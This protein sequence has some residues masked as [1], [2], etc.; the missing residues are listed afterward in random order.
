MST[1]KSQMSNSELPQI[2]TS[3]NL[4]LGDI[5]KL[6]APTNPGLHDQIY[7]IKFINNSKLV[8]INSNGS[9]TLTLSQLGKIQ[10]ESIAN[11]I[12]LSRVSSPSFVVQNNLAIKKY[13]SIYFGEPFPYVVN[14]FISNIEN[15]MIEVTLL[16][17][18]TIIYIDFAY[19]GIPE[20]LNIDKIVVRDKL[21]ETQLAIQNDELQDSQTSLDD[22]TLVQDPNSMLDYDLKSYDSKDEIE[23]L[24]IDTIELGQELDDLEHEVNVSEEEQRYSLDK[25]TNDYLDKLINAY[26]PEQRNDA[27]I[28]Q[29]HNE[30]NYYIQLRSIYSNFDA[31]NYP[32]LP[33]ERG[34]HYKYL[35][36]Q[37]FN[38][39]KKMSFLFPVLE[40]ARN[41]LISESPDNEDELTSENAFNYQSMGEFIETL[42][43]TSLKWSNNSSKEKINNYKEHI[44][45]LT[46]LFDSY[47][48]NSAENINV[49]SQIMMI[50]DSIGDFYNYSI[51]KGSLS[52]SR[53]MIDVYNP[54]LM[55]LE[56]HYVNNKK[57]TRPTKLTANDYV[58]IVGFISLPLPLFKFS[59]INT[60]YTN[61]GDKAN[62]NINFI[63]ISDLLNT[64]TMYNTHILE[65]SDKANY[66]NSHNNIHNN[67]FLK[68]INHFTIDK[69]VDLPYLEKMNYLLE[70]FIP[71][72][73][74][75]IGE[76]ISAYV[77]DSLNYRKY[78]LISFIYDLQALNV[79]LYNL[80]YNDY[81][82]IKSVVQ[83]N[84]EVYKKIYKSNEAN[85][86]KFLYNI[87]A[88]NSDAIRGKDE[89]IIFSFDLLAKD[90]K[91]DLFNLYNIK[92]ELFNSYEELY[93]FIY[94]L[95][96]GEFFLQSLNKNIMDLVVGNLLDN[97]I[98]AREKELVNPDPAIPDTL[99]GTTPLS[100]KD[101]LLKDLDEIQATC[102]RYVLSKSYKTLQS[103]ENDNNKLIFYDSIYDKTLYSMANQFQNERKVMD[104][105]SFLQFLTE[106]LMTIMKLT[107]ANALREAKSIIEEK[108]EIIDG[109]YA[110]LK[111]K[112]SSKNYIYKREN[113][114]WV[115]DPTF[116][117]K[118]YIENNQIFCD[119]NKECIT[120]DDKCNSIDGTKKTNLN[121]EVDN[122][123]KTF[124]SKYNFSIE[125]IKSK[126]NSNYENAKKRIEKLASLNKAKREYGN[127]YLLSLEEIVE[128]KIISSPYESVRAS[129]LKLKDLSLK[130]ELLKRFC[131]NYTRNAI[132]DENANWL[133]CIKT[134]VKLVPQFLLR[135]A[136]VFLTKQNYVLELDTICAQQG[137]ISD[138]NNYWVDKH[139]GYIIK[140]IEFDND[141]GYDDKGFKVFSREQLE[142][143]YAINLQPLAKSLNPNIQVIINIIKAITLMMGINLSHN[144]EVIINNVLLVL[145]SN[146]PTKQKYEE[147]LLKTA[148]KEGKAKNNPSYDDMYN[149]SL[150]LLTLTFIVYA[151]QINI[152]SLTSKKTF[153]G[154]IKS[155]S[156]YPLD[157]EQDKTSI[158][159]IACIANKIK[160]SIVPWNSILKMSES[161][162]IKN[163]EQLIT[164]YVVTNKE[165][166]EHLN[167]KREF[168]LTQDTRDNS[169][170]DYLNINNWHT[171]NPP[172]N[173]IKIPS[174]ELE[175]LGVNFKTTLYDTFS[176]GQKNNIKDM[177]ESKAISCANHIIELIQNVVKSNTPLLK[178]SNDN[179]FLENAC[180]NSEKNTINYFTNAN[181]AIIDYNNLVGFYS[182]IVDGI[183]SLTYSPQIYI[184]LNTQQK[185]IT[186]YSAFSEEVVYKAFIYFCNFANQLPLD[187]ELKGL[188]M[189]KP[190][191]FDSTKSIKEI[192][193]ALKNEG[194]IYNF[195]SFVELI[196][197]VSKNNTINVPINFAIINNIEALRIIIEAYSN[198]SYYKLDDIFISKLELMLD[199]FSII[200]ENNGELRELKN[201]LGRTNMLLK[202]KI[203]QTVNKQTN[204]SKSEFASFSQTLD[205]VIDVENITFYQNYINNILH[206]FPSIIS[207]KNVNYDAIPKY[208]N[209]STLHYS[210]IYN[211]IKKYYVTLN[212][213]D[214]KHELEYAFKIVAKKLQLLTQLMKVFLYNKSLETSTKQINSIFDEKLITL[215]YNYIFYNIYNELLSINEDQDFML[216]I[217]NVETTDYNKDD[218]IKSIINYIMCFSNIMNNHYSLINNGY[219]RVKEKIVMAKEKE[220]TLIT[221]FLKNLSDEEREI[222]TILKNNKLEKWNVGMQKGLTQYV[223]ENY[224][225]EREA[226]DKQALKERK[227]QQ[228]NNVTS[229]NKEIYD[230]DLDEQMQNDAA[231]DAEEYS[232][233]NIP[234]DN[235][236]N[237]D[238]ADEDYANGFHED[239][240]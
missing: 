77:P 146:I 55:M 226:L 50:N 107:K 219:A 95:D 34:M 239:Y 53:F 189:D 194:K 207:N 153:P 24:I 40:N 147:L 28:K 56:S 52:K 91:D 97:F 202:Q 220:K 154:C 45:A 149:S 136:N 186:Q 26:L 30:I 150:L 156:G 71:T 114:V 94:S 89:N 110:V 109:D 133:Y 120:K 49:N 43:S 16:P 25:Q 14:G 83:D 79:D 68:T 235:D 200:D 155:F 59:L 183:A 184:P 227:L 135:L 161:T 140:T 225:E 224:D 22:E 199:S 180:C 152:P 23:S 169:I 178:N 210:D 104:N 203:L 12:I 78:S 119:S 60:N 143:D 122:I 92:E 27:V 15:D 128:S 18:N 29:I 237:Y 32:L 162:I 112:A 179:P 101:I 115:L 176:R 166:V 74:A 159:Y 35:K 205:L 81:K 80:H 3:I 82:L 164:R 67:S 4:Q 90:L 228:N 240:D 118:F 238:N 232:M 163:I 148:K 46:Q 130:Y 105:V 187:D 139:S 121:A 191:N 87:K 209:L 99:D 88:L 151:I 36:E 38:L 144:H 113:N 7:F 160:S 2:V 165:L 47:V 175:P 198:N 170:P 216:Q 218:F 5:I 137:T 111:D 212:T 41:L 1:I 44:R 168:L 21:D 190:V 230:L 231:I 167:K 58:N 85:F 54:G 134:S 223:K 84:I 57:F 11:I 138:D 131:L 196:Q 37:I 70:S 8:L 132:K 125:E 208:W 236:F 86:A 13:I 204:I 10:E 172:L 62:L 215:F 192:I 75:F 129:I 106:K 69:S 211:I 213:F 117:D 221:D 103:L 214:S 19:S 66:V 102:E 229:M 157:D 42:V 63:N 182:D 171:F 108:R 173:D 181:K 233:K 234:D 9:L 96:C 206:I 193:S 177:V 76:F 61:I 73:K 195:A 124:E 174:Q 188:C 123:L 39:N 142:N 51:L 93:S 33:S 6:D 127:N 222:E 31:N 98:K 201:Y 145:N 158:T 72:N 100:S 185:I 141:E 217:Q 20:D 17:E 64:N 116:E 65:N 126:I 48:N 197:I